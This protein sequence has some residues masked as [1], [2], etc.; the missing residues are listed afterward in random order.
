MT[1]D[2]MVVWVMVAVPPILETA[3]G[4][5]I[6][7]GLAVFLA[8]LDLLFDFL[9][10]VVVWDPEQPIRTVHG[11]ALTIPRGAVQSLG[12]LVSTQILSGDGRSVL[13][14]CATP[15]HVTRVHDDHRGISI[16]EHLPLD[17]C[18]PHPTRMTNSLLYS[19]RKVDGGLERSRLY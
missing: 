9:V 7:R 13:G 1:P 10:M 2:P 15:P 3:E 12:I 6:W 8:T 5:E 19:Q 16:W 14:L 11:V 17:H 4:A 18:S